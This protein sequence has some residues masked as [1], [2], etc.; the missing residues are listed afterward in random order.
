MYLYQYNNVSVTFNK[1]GK[2]IGSISS[3]NAPSQTITYTISAGLVTINYKN[4][5]QRLRYFNF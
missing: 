4:P 5:C 2:S 3:L 1:N